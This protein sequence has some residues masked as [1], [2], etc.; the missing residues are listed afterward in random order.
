MALGLAQLGILNDEIDADPL[1]RGYS[2]M[3]D[4]QIVASL[5]FK[6]RDFWVDLTSAQMFQSI[7]LAELAAL[8]S[9]EQVRTDRILS[10]TGEIKTGP[11]TNAREEFLDV[12]GIGSTTISN[13]ASLANRPIGRG[14]ELGLGQVR[15]PYLGRMRTEAAKGLI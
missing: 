4:D 6:N 3:T 8:S 12:F 9:A 1:I 2:G 7:D 10:L 14:V 13:L 11:G 5:N 15:N